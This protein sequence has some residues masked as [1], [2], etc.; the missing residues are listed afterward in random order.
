MRTRTTAWIIAGVA[1]VFALRGPSGVLQRV[2][3]AAALPARP[4]AALGLPTRWIQ[5][6]RR[7][8][9]PGSA[10]A[11]FEVEASLCA[12]L[13]AAVRRSAYP[14]QRPLP[15]GAVATPGEVDARASG[16]G[17]DT[18]RVRVAHPERVRVEQGVVA[19]DV[20]VGRVARVHFREDVP[21]RPSLLQRAL[22]ALRL[23][24]PPTVPPRDAIDVALITGAGERVGGAV[25]G[26]PEG[27]PSA[28]VV[29]G[30]VLGVE[31]LHLAVHTPESR[32]LRSGV[33]EVREPD[34]PGVTRS[35]AAHLCDGFALGELR[36]V[37]V[38]R[39]L[40]SGRDD[41]GLV[42]VS[43]GVAPFLDFES[44]LNQLLVLGLAED[45]AAPPAPRPPGRPATDGRWRATRALSVGDLSPWRSTLRIQA[46]SHG[47][48][49]RGAAVVDGARL[50]GRVAR[51]DAA[52]ATVA[53]LSEP[54][55]QVIAL[56][57]P[58]SRP[59]A[60]P[61]VLGSLRSR[62]SDGTGAPV[63]VWSP[64]ADALARAREWADVH[65]A[66]GRIGVRLFTGSGMS[67]VPRGLLLGRATLELP[68]VEAARTEG[69]D[70]PADG[71]ADPVSLRIPLRIE[72]SARAIGG[73][74]LYLGEAPDDSAEAGR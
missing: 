58:A 55:F 53:P 49:V 10:P 33:V 31:P 67:L 64:D 48:A 63:L 51:A 41:R 34:V 50:L 39:R 40:G 74:R 44:G 38:A 70:G 46:T 69:G 52:G 16:A 13:E 9:E 57:S 61:L 6:A 15:E 21:D 19:G 73:L 23:E 24:R 37:E 26:I 18:I 43:L 62:G 36:E 54:G 72:G 22:R 66:P 1:G 42:E 65:G 45:G 56:A 30:V 68:P 35:A 71:G 29:G 3:G 4:V 20:Y 17:R 25:R 14:V 27:E 32:T 2:A 7:S 5:S 60:I 8:G 12:E 11:R 59:D 28:L 47:G